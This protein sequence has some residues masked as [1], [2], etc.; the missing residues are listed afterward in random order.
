MQIS[1]G[2]RGRFA[3][4]YAL[5]G[6]VAPF[7]APHEPLEFFRGLGAQIHI[8]HLAKLLGDR[9]QRLGPQ[10]ND[11]VALFLVV[12]LGVVGGAVAAAALWFRGTRAADLGSVSHTWVAELRAG[13]PYDSSR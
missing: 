11:V 6:L 7:D 9:K 13:E 2:A 4:A 12:G 10:A 5:A 8:V 1:I 3:P